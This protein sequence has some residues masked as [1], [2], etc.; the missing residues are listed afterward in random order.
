MATT[1][2]ITTSTALCGRA[3]FLVCRLIRPSRGAWSLKR[4]IAPASSKLPEGL[5]HMAAWGL[6]RSGH[7]WAMTP[8]GTPCMPA[9]GT[10]NVQDAPPITGMRSMRR[11][12]QRSTRAG[13]PSGSRRSNETVPYVRSVGAGFPPALFRLTTAHTVDIT[14]REAFPRLKNLD[15]PSGQQLSPI[16]SYT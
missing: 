11:A 1:W 9:R 2:L 10:L 13:C 6:R 5:T 4:P 15:R 14:G 12:E 3:S 7:R 8:S 16:G